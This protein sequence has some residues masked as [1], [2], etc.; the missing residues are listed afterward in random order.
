MRPLV[1]SEVEAGEVDVFVVVK[2][3]VADPAP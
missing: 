1:H 3:D 2:P